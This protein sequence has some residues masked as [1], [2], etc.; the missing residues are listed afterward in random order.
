M[1]HIALELSLISVSISIDRGTLAL[2]LVVAPIAFIPATVVSIHNS[3][4]TML[5]PILK[6]SS[7]YIAS[8]CPKNTLAIHFAASKVTFVDVAILEL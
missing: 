7:V 1:T 8:Q 5:E 3:A 4:F 2:L 6:S